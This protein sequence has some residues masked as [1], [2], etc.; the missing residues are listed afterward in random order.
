ML[1]SI[2]TEDDLD[3]A[4]AIANPAATSVLESFAPD[5]TVNGGMIYDLESATALLRSTS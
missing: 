5:V 3:R 4:F 1:A 2:Q